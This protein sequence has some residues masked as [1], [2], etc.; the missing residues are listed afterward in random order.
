MTEPRHQNLLF[1]VA[2]FIIMAVF[3]V[4]LAFTV[5]VPSDSDR[6]SELV[7]MTVGMATDDLRGEIW[8]GAHGGEPLASCQQVANETGLWLVPASEP[9]GFIPCT[10]EI[11]VE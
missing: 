9:T 6:A 3:A 1:G 10:I 7:T 11:E 5:L 2:L 4:M 8:Y